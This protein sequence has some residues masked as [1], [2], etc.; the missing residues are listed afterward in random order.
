P[1]GIRNLIW[2]LA[3]LAGGAVV[4][5]GLLLAA[6]RTKASNDQAD[7]ALKQSETAL[8]QA[9]LAFESQV[10]ERFTKAVEQLGHEKRA[11][12]LGAIYALERIA[13]DSPRDRDTIVETL[14]AYIRE[15]APWPPL[16]EKGKPLDDAA[17]KIEKDRTGM[18]APIDIAA[19]LTVICRR[20]EDD[21]NK[22]NT[23]NLNNID[24]RGLDM[25]KL[26][27]S[28]INL[29]E[30]NLSW[31]SLR[32]VNLNVTALGWS[33]L[34]YASLIGAKLERTYMTST[35]LLKVD[36]LT[37]QQID[38]IRYLRDNPP[39]NLPEGLVL[40]APYDG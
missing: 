3:T 21:N 29:M 6:R 23:I 1:E 15:L 16:D 22:R 33:D 10:T 17:L 39:K 37:Q 19:A 8:R 4:G 25:S 20:L 40:P 36:N 12:R 35:N 11:V 5:I 26:N 18:R 31:S 32:D 24:L 30:S 38:G 7:A 27:L 13:K 34:S 2:S 14:A 28:W 9:E